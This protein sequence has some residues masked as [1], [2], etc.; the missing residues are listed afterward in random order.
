MLVRLARQGAGPRF[1]AVLPTTHLEPGAASRS[2]TEFKG[3]ETDDGGAVSAV[4]MRCPDH[5]CTDFAASVIALEL[6]VPTPVAPITRV[7]P[8]DALVMTESGLPS[9]AADV[10]VGCG[11][12]VALC[13]VGAIRLGGDDFRA[14]VSAAGPGW[15]I[16]ETSAGSFASVRDQ[17]ATYTPLRESPDNS[18]VAARTERFLNSEGPHRVDA[19]R[20]LC[21]NVLLA[22]GLPARLS[23][24]GDHAAWAELAAQVGDSVAIFELEANGDLLDTLRRL[25]ANAAVLA[26]RNAFPRESSL[27]FVVA[28]VLPNERVDFYDV[29]DD[30]QGRLGL[31]VRTLTACALLALVCLSPQETRDLL[32]TMPPVSRTTLDALAAALTALGVSGDFARLGLV[33]RK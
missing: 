8:V 25:L 12:C 11:L 22:K 18:T 23:N 14:E 26:A 9:V 17:L 6:A 2:L 29:I 19:L 10:C 7:C 24:P 21:R 20:L 1:D 16:V 33:P 3:F 31:T 4:C 27:Y 5:P 32:S 15:D 30:V 28:H 13:P